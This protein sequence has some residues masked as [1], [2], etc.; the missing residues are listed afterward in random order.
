MKKVLS[1]MVALVLGISVFAFIPVKADASLPFNDVSQSDWFYTP[2]V[3]CYDNGILNGISTDEFGPNY[4]M[5]RGMMVTVLWRYAG[6]DNE[7]IAAAAGGGEFSDVPTD[8]Y[9]Y[10]AVNWAASKGIV[11]GVV[12]DMVLGSG[13]ALFA[14]N[15]TITREQMY[16]I[17]YRYMNFDGLTI[18]LDEGPR[19]QF[20]D[21]NQIDDWAKPALHLMYDAGIM[22]RDNDFDNY[23]RPQDQAL[24]GEIAGAMYF[25]N[26]YAKPI[27]RY[28]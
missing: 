26:M 22:F 15:D 3:W 21:E 25:F 14:P 9:Y 2:L 13:N 1:I 28:L 6:S 8:A 7:R 23:A 19:V 12:N 16:T 20:A 4:S 18:P 5:T 10:Q 27:P 17:L 24:R 11:N